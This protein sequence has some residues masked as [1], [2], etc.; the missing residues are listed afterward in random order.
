ME[1][2]VPF[3]DA[4][5]FQWFTQY[6][7][8]PLEDSMRELDTLWGIDELFCKSATFFE[9]SMRSNSSTHRHNAN[10][11]RNLHPPTIHG[12]ACAVVTEASTAVQHNNLHTIDKR[13]DHFRTRGFR[14]KERASQAFPR[15]AERNI[16]SIPGS[17]QLTH[18]HLEKWHRV[19]E[20]HYTSN[21]AVHMCTQRHSV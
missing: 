20:E 6:V 1:L 2:Q 10:T 19:T 14:M 11:Q 9:W 21:S 7:V 17:G 8:G 13:L 16:L 15:W 18:R 3:F 5:F 12:P 4:V